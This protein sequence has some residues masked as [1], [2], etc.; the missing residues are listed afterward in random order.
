M[1]KE[2]IFQSKEKYIYLTLNE[3]NS[4]QFT[5]HWK[6]WDFF[7]TRH[8]S[9]MGQYFVYEIFNE[10]NYNS[11]FNSKISYPKLAIYVNALACDQT[12]ELE[13][14]DYRRTWEWNLEYEYIHE[15]KTYRN[16]IS[17]IPTEINRMPLWGD[18]ML[19]YGVWDSKPNWKQLRQAYEKTWWFWRSPDQIR[20][21]QLNRILL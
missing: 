11:K 15:G 8:P 4:L 13:W 12:I 5:N 18:M 10:I 19:I 14:V 2:E 7:N 3:E 9:S 6:K 17:E 20:N 16:Y 1:T 21:I